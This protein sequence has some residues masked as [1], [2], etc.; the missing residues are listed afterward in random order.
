MNLP[1]ANALRNYSPVIFTTGRAPRED[2]PPAI[3]PIPLI[4]RN[5]VIFTGPKSPLGARGILRGSC[6]RMP[7]AGGL[8]G[9]VDFLALRKEEK[10]YPKSGLVRSGPTTVQDSEILSF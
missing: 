10:Q 7:R 9:I 1:D 4:G 8:C 2:S 3:L 6:G 5:H